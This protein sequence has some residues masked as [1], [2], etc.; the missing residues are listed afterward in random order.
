MAHRI[1]GWT[2]FTPGT[3]Y[4]PGVVF[5]LH[6]LKIQS[7]ECL[8]CLGDADFDG[9][10]ESEGF[11]GGEILDSAGMFIEM[12]GFAEIAHIDETLDTVRE[13]DV[14]TMI[15]DGGDNPVEDLSDFVLHVVDN[16]DIAN[17]VFDILSFAFGGRGVFGDARYELLVA[18]KLFGTEFAVEVCLD[19]AVDLEVWVA[20]D[21]GG[22]VRIVLEGESEVSEDFLGIESLG[23]ARED[24]FGEDVL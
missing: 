19:D 8:V 18:S 2:T 16:L 9:V 24:M 7:S 5:C 20:S 10:A 23:H 6:S 1:R 15:G 14:D 22:E 11:V 3:S 13:L 21:R 17:R 12:V 4:V